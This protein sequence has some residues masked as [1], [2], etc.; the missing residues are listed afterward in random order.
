MTEE[1]AVDAE[2]AVVASAGDDTD[3]EEDVIDPQEILEDARDD[4][5][6]FLEGLLDAME[7]D[8]DVSA[9]ILEDG[10]VAASI[11]GGDGGLLI[12][13]RG[14]TLEAIQELLRTV[15]QRQAQ[16][17]VR[18]TL[19]VEGYRERRREAVRRMAEQAAE[20]AIED[21]E[22]ELE[23][24]NAYERKIVHETIAGI[25]GISSFSEGQEPRRRVLIQRD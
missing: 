6:D 24:M 3:P 11:S 17:R 15:V 4:A 7:A 16:T 18:V 19:D 8:G 10:T 21:G 14:Q 25:D 2:E 1:A 23:P 22:V 9:D 12:G 20:R 13:S 5:L